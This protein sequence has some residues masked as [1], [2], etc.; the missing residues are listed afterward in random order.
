[1]GFQKNWD[2]YFLTSNQVIHLIFA[3][4][5]DEC[6]KLPETDEQWEIEVGG[7]IENYVFP[8]VAAWDGYYIHV[9]LQLK[10]IFSFKESIR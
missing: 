9:N 7:F 8:A 5:Y 6:K 1:M 3:Y 4:F 10:A 2:A